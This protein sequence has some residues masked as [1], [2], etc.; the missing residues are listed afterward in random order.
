MYHWDMI[1][2]IE[3][4]ERMVTVC[5]CEKCSHVWVSDGIPRRCARCK[6]STWNEDGSKL[7]TGPVPIGQKAIVP[8]GQDNPNGTRKKKADPVNTVRP[9]PVDIS[10][11]AEGFQVPQV[12]KSEAKPIPRGRPEPVLEAPTKDNIPGR[13]AGKKKEK[14]QRR[15]A[16]QQCSHGLIYHPGCTD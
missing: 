10:T 6:A 12:M 16:D 8:I 4:V 9:V 1:S 2:N 7:Q 13:K 15:G 3:I 14:P 11:P 5:G